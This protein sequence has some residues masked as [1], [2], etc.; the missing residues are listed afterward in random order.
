M[1]HLLEPDVAKRWRVEQI[2]SSEW[3]AMDPRLMQLNAAEQAAM[4]HAQEEKK[5]HLDNK[6]QSV[7]KKKRESADDVTILKESKLKDSQDMPGSKTAGSNPGM[8]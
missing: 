6:K 7:T 4:N 3:M 1:T 8:A 5:K 2:L